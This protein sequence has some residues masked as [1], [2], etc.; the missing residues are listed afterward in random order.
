V[1][2]VLTPDCPHRE[3]AAALLRTALDDVGLIGAQFPTTVITTTRDANRIGFIGSPTILV[4]GHDPFA[5]PGA[6]PALACRIYPSPTGPTG[7]PHCETSD[8][9]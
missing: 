8:R 2:L 4:N 5:A 3:A 7:I 1:E 9:R 6:R